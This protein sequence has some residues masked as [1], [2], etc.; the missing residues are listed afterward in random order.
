MSGPVGRQRHGSLGQV[1]RVRLRRR[2]SIYLL[3]DI[4]RMQAAS[5]RLG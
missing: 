5:L 4:P 3:S 2:I 1:S